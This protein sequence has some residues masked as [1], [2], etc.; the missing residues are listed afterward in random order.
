MTW[1]LYYADGVTFSD[2][3]GAP[4][5]APPFGVLCLLYRDADVAGG[6]AILHRVNWYWW[7]GDKWWG[8]DRDGYI[9]Q[10]MHL[11]AMWPKLGRTV[12]NAVYQRAF[13]RAIA[14]RAGWLN[15]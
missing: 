15:G 3:D 2:V 7:Q 10:A 4:G 5:E 14:D 13:D 1:C 11:G 9:D 6:W 8:G 12:D